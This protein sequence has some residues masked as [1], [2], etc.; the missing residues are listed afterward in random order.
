MTGIARTSGA[1]TIANAL[2]TGVGCAVGIGLYA[3][4]RVE[5][6]TDPSATTPALVV[7][8]ESHTPV[9]EASLRTAVARYYPERGAVARLSLRSDVPVARGL[10]SSSAVSTAVLLA[11][12]KEARR[13]PTALEIGKM[14]AEV[15]RQAGVSATGALDDALAGLE[16]GLVVTHNIRGEVL[17]RAPLDPS[18][19]V[20]LYIPPRSHPPSPNLRSAFERE[21]ESG[22]LA[23]RAAIDGD[24]PKAMR[25]NTEL[26]ERTMGYAY[27][28]LRDRLRSH[29]A[30]ASG[31]SGLGPALA[32][33]AP[34]QI[35]PELVDV[36]P[37]DDAQKLIVPFTRVPSVEGDPS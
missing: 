25:L 31:V 10:K 1:I 15:G 3:E 5:L 7:P 24:W 2:P 18:L 16:P 32:V 26:V 8:R 19:G 22:G 9:V 12:A 37:S 36:F 27:G 14:S 28:E 6:S 4:A 13:K 33:V 20:A 23:A 17:R 11:V 34:L 30:V 29:G 35:L 21:K